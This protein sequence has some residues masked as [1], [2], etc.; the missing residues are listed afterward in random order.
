ML[1]LFLSFILSFKCYGY[2]GCVVVDYESVVCNNEPVNFAL[3]AKGTCTI[4][5]IEWI[6]SNTQNDMETFLGPG[7][8]SVTFV[9]SELT[10]FSISYYDGELGQQIDTVLSFKVIEPV[11]YV[12]IEPQNPCIGE[13]IKLRAEGADEGIFAWKGG[14]LDNSSK[15]QNLVE[16]SDSIV[17]E[18]QNYTLQWY[19]GNTG[20][21]CSIRNFNYTVNAKK[22]TP[23]VIDPSN[24]I[25]ICEGDIVNLKIKDANDE[26]T[27]IWQSE[28][29]FIIGATFDIKPENLTNIAVR[30]FEDGCFRSENILINVRKIPSFSIE[31]ANAVMCQGSSLRLNVV[32]SELYDE[33]SYSWTGGGTIRPLNTF[34]NVVEITPESATTV[35]TASWEFGDCKTS[36]KSTVTISEN[37]TDIIGD[38][39][40]N[41]CNGEAVDLTVNTPSNGVIKWYESS[42]PN[43]IEAQF[44]TVS[45]E[46]T[47]TYE[48]N[49]TDG[50]C[51]DSGKITVIVNPKPV[52]EISSSVGYKVCEGEPIDLQ[53]LFTNGSFNDGFVWN[54]EDLDSLKYDNQ[55][56]FVATQSE[57]VTATWIDSLNLCKEVVSENI[58]FDVLSKPQE[59]FLGASKQVLCEGESVTLNVEG[60][61]FDNFILLRDADAEIT[62]DGKFDDGSIE[63]SPGKTT[64]YI[65]LW[66]N[67][68]CVISSDTIKVIV[69]A[70]PDITINNNKKVCPGEEFE[71]N[72]QP[73]DY[74]FYLW[75]G[76]DIPP[77]DLVTGS[78]LSRGVNESTLSYSLRI[79]N[80][81]CI[82]DTVVTINL[83]DL[84]INAV[85][86]KVGNEV[87]EGE[88]AH[89][90]VDGVDSYLWEDNEIL[91]GDLSDKPTAVPTEDFTQLKVQAFKEGCLVEDSLIL[92][93]KE[94]PVATIRE[95][96]TVCFGDTVQLG[97]YGGQNYL[98]KPDLFLDN[99]EIQNPVSTPEE[100][101][102]YTLTVIAENGCTD[103]ASVLVSV[104]YEDCEIDLNKIF[105]P[106]TITPNG[107]NINDTWVIPAIADLQDYSV[108]IFTEFGTTVY[109][110]TSYQNEFNGVFKGLLPEGTYYYI[111][112]HLNSD[113]KRTGTLTI[114]R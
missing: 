54:I 18:Q 107:D 10:N 32:A 12:S 86:D 70:M 29:S 55:L 78:K 39:T 108:T 24:E 99:N 110:K 61:S 25:T 94:K 56:S 62:L 41:I 22:T 27:Y 13:T 49:W 96:A 15:D 47:T 102:I 95:E 52:L 48:V 111:I 85:S 104:N 71:I 88:Q 6:F 37:A 93:L 89:L 101:T 9:N 8:H 68:E 1:V 5:K 109:N 87:C 35:Y 74:S 14:Q 91:S 75:S 46:K 11:R 57:Y 77:S 44:I 30:T 90:F 73:S 34:G 97:G 98:W 43:S 17:F 69:N 58:Y 67:E 60:A 19:L 50:S 80:N 76:G 36:A 81:N 4:N 16:I 100:S 82:L 23:L 20:N 21:A 7:P 113:N 83:V 28:D 2:Q 33:F 79:N 103:E 65:A 26:N 64:N 106:N 112:R 53:V 59:I 63:I 84:N 45:P 92:Y 3:K 51:T 40:I 66:V 72:I 42:F 38:K 105:V 31:P 114:I